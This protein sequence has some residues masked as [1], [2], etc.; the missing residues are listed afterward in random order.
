MY[1]KVYA[2]NFTHLVWCLIV[3]VMLAACMI[4]FFKAFYYV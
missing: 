4:A 2:T 3:S 1:Y